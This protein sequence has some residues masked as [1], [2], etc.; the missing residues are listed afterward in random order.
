M[1][2]I[3]VEDKLP[4]NENMILFLIDIGEDDRF[5]IDLGRYS[6]SRKEFIS[7]AS[8][9]YLCYCSGEEEYILKCITHW[10]PLPERP[11]D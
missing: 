10:Q 5:T 7:Q 9:C 2:W 11:K 4:E 8:V 3:K 6:L 1:T